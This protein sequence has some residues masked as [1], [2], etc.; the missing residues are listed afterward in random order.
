MAVF[1]TLLN[2]LLGASYVVAPLGAIAAVVVFVA[3]LRRPRGD[4]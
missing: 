4:T 3:L 2:W 1:D